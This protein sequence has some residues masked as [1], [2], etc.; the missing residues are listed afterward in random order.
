MKLI[1]STL[2]I[3]LLTCERYAGASARYQRYDSSPTNNVQRGLKKRPS[4]PQQGG[5]WGAGSRGSS[6]LNYDNGG[7]LGNRSDRAGARGGD[8][9]MDRA[10]GHS[11]A[12]DRNDSGITVEKAEYTYGDEALGSFKLTSDKV[13]GFVLRELDVTQMD[14]WTVGLFMRMQRPGEEGPIVS[15]SPAIAASGASANVVID[16]A[17]K[18]KRALQDDL[19]PDYGEGQP[20]VGDDAEDPGAN[21]GDEEDLANPT[22]PELDHSGTFTIPARSTTA[23]ILNE[24]EYGTGFDAYLLDEEGRPVIGP[25]TFYMLP[26]EAMEAEKASA[27]GKVPNYGINKHDHSIKKHKGPKKGSGKP[28]KKGSTGKSGVKADGIALVNAA[29]ANAMYANGGLG[30]GSTG[31]PILGTKPLL[32]DYFLETDKELYDLGGDVVVTYD[33]SAGTGYRLRRMLQDRSMGVVAGRGRGAGGNGGRAGAGG[34]GGRGG[35]GGRGRGSDDTA[36]SPDDPIELKV[37][38]ADIPP[39]DDVTTTVPPVTDAPDLPYD[40]PEPIGPD[41]GPVGEPYE[42]EGEDA[43]DTEDVTLFKV[44]VFMRM[45]HPQGGS[46]YPIVSV[47][48]CDDGNCLLEDVSSGEVSF[49]TNELDAGLNG[50][51]HGLGYAVWI[52]NGAG[53]EVAGPF[54]FYIKGESTEQR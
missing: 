2:S 40:G 9:R 22:L 19:G 36:L 26:T 50:A 54:D 5:G 27:F 25:A 6:V 37:I 38:D 10:K 14:Q 18:P 44:G 3:A 29:S 8:S 31:N 23:A 15:V 45:A 49:S 4:K 20:P 51:V 52:L 21:M 43:V 33:L 35:G 24:D 42:D 13:D 47:P 16:A 46:L 32:S 12:M 48:L 39:I 11:A 53:G 1:S 41:N 34:N 28:S 30:A 17:K 7:G